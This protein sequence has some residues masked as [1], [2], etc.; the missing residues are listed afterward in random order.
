MFT[1]T[2][3]GIAIDLF[4]ECRNFDDL[5]THSYMNDPEAATDEPSS[6]KYFPDFFGCRA[7]SNVEVFRNQTE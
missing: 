6:W 3:R 1:V 7:G 5:A 4:A 2:R